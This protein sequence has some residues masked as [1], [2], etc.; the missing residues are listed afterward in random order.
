[1]RRLFT[2]IRKL[3]I[4]C[5]EILLLEVSIVIS[6][7]FLLACRLLCVSQGLGGG[8]HCTILNILG[9]IS[10]AEEVFGQENNVPQKQ[11]RTTWL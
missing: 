8:G 3:Q 5:Y 7:L 2:K 1:M 11:I 4:C 10:Y 6:T 9:L